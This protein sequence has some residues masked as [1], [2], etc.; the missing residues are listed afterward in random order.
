[1]KKIPHLTFS[2][3]IENIFIT[4]LHLKPSFQALLTSG[5]FLCMLF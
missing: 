3:K 5:T 4:D 2:G 1:M